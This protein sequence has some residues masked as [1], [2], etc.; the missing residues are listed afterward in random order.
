MA[1]WTPVETITPKAPQIPDSSTTVNPYLRTTVPL[2]YQYTPDTL[3]QFN[4]PGVSSFRTSPL[5]PNA[6]PSIN[7]LAQGIAN[8]AVAGI[9]S[10]SGLPTSLST[11]T[12]GTGSL[13]NGTTQTGTITIAGVFTLVWV[14]VN[15]PARVRL[16]STASARNTDVPR[17]VSVPPVAGLANY[18]ISD[19]YLTGAASIPLSFPCATVIVGANQ[20]ASA[21]S[22]I[23]WTITNYSGGT[24]T[25]TATLKFLPMEKT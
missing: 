6:L 11:A 22:T 17:P 16:Y 21:S 25:I 13:G 4:R 1:G 14:I 24:T 3:R 2:P 7:S 15:L 18:V 23:Y 5:P 9:V 20:D 10:G 19:H 12:I 8:T